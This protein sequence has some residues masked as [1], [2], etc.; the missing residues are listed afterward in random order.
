MRAGQFLN[1]QR[2]VVPARLLDD[3]LGSGEAALGPLHPSCLR[4]CGPRCPKPAAPHCL[5]RL[6]PAQLL[7][8]LLLLQHG[9]WWGR[10][11]S[12]AHPDPPEGSAP[13][14]V[15]FVALLWARGGTSRPAPNAQHLHTPWALGA[16]LHSETL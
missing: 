9:H 4:S 12:A 14:P 8:L 10:S 11:S 3:I 2:P 16:R 15:T 7:L 5:P 1:K 6:P 13:H